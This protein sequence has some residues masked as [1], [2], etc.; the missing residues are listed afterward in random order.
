M[1][2]NIYSLGVCLLEIGLWVSFVDYDLAIGT[3]SISEL[4]LS[5]SGKSKFSFST[6]FSERTKEQ[7]VTLARYRLPG[8]M[9]NKY[10]EIVEACL[11]CPDP[12]NVDFGDGREFED[13]DGIRVG[14]RYIEKVSTKTDIRLYTR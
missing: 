6:L 10:A 7:L 4:L 13:E 11:T 5:P 3:R 9:G 14:D 12:E 2:H 1:R 8:S